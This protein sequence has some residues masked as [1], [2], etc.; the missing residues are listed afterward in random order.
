LVKHREIR[1][2]DIFTEN[3]MREAQEDIDFIPSITVLRNIP[4]IVK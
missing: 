3:I 4:H 1:E 2:K